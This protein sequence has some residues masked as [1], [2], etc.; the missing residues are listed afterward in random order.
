M[1]KW[2]NISLRGSN[3]FHS[4]CAPGLVL[5]TRWDRVRTP[6]RH[7]SFDALAVVVGTPL[8]LV[9]GKVIHNH[10]VEGHILHFAV[11][12]CQD[13]AWVSLWVVHSDVAQRHV[14]IV[15]V[16]RCIAL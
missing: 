12:I 16:F 11:A 1:R 4:G 14:N 13:D 9:R 2:R 5:K 8:S 10:T 6:A 3:G 7:A 15:S